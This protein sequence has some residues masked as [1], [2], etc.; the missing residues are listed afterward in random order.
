MEDRINQR[1]A[2]ILAEFE[3]R[4]QIRQIHVTTDDQEVKG[5]NK[6]LKIGESTFKFVCRFGK[7]SGNMA[8]Q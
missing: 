6:L 1:Q 7:C 8:S 3:R 5:H 4:K 2:E